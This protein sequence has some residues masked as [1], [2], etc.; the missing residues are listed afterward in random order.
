VLLKLL[1]Y[2][3]KNDDTLGLLHVVTNEKMQF[4]SFTLEDEYRTQ[5]LRGETRIPAGTYQI[6]LRN[7]GGLTRKY[8]GRFPNIHKGMLWLRDVPNFKFIYIHVGNRDEDTEG[9]ILVGDTADSNVDG[10]GMIGSSRAAYKRIYPM[11][12]KQAELVNLAIEITDYDTV[13]R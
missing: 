4:L 13:V 5:K 1:R 10:D 6:N 3:S 11:L 12:A 9:C 7:E 2:S 8:A